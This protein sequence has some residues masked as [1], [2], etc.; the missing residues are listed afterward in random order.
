LAISD[1]F[2]VTITTPDSMKLQSG[3]RKYAPFT[4]GHALRRW[5]TLRGIGARG[6]RVYVDRNVQLMRHPEKIALGNNVMLKEGVRL[7]PTNPDASIIVGDWTTLGYHCFLFAST[8]IEIGANCL[9]APFCYFV[10]SDHGIAADSLI[11]EQDMNA[12][13]IRI[14]SDVWL[15]TGVVVTK[16][17]TIG[18]GA[19]IGARSVVTEDVAAGAVVAGVPARFIRYRQ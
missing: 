7:C 12:R 11:R 1:K 19:V 4:L 6:D 15:G 2:A 14:G 10:D 5:W 8:R 18:D 3:V 17:V 9:I 13:P 16:G